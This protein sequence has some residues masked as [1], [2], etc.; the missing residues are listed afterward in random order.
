MSKGSNM[1]P[2][3]KKKRSVYAMLLLIANLIIQKNLI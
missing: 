1:E 3:L 2:Y